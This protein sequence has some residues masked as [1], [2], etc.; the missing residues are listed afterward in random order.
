MEILTFYLHLPNAGIT[1]VPPWQLCLTNLAVIL[2]L[3]SHGG[4]DTGKLRSLWWGQQLLLIHTPASDLHPHTHTEPSS[5]RLHPVPRFFP[6]SSYPP[7]RSLSMQLGRM[8]L[9]R[10]LHRQVC[11][12][13]VLWVGERDKE[14]STVTFCSPHRYEKDGQSSTFLLS[15]RLLP[16]AS[17][18][19]L[20]VECSLW[21]QNKV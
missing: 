17:P 14:S 15:R 13:C 9:Y 6:P 2:G 10:S 4:K 11:L 18:A 8:A 16:M 3:R 12:P 7:R 1:G 20:Y 19:E 5:A 21:K